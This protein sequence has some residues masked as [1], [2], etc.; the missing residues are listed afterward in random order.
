MEILACRRPVLVCLLKNRKLSKKYNAYQ[1]NMSHITQRRMNN[2]PLLR[3]QNQ[4]LSRNFA[5]MRVLNSVLKLRY[6]VL[7]SAVGGGVTISKVCIV[8]LTYIFHNCS[9]TYYG[10]LIL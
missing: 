1:R 3:I 8:P 6:L 4:Q 9:F 7:G 10:F 2:N 5:I